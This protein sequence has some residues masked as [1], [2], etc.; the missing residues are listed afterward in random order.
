MIDITKLVLGIL[1]VALSVLA[2]YVIPYLRNIA[3]AKIGEYK[4]N[5]ILQYTKIAVQA[6]EQ[7]YAGPGR[8]AEKK[9]AV[10]RF[11]EEKGFTLDA[12]LID[13]FIE[14]AVLDLKKELAE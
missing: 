7:V 11:L 2:I 6:A 4:Y 10:L 9:A 12:D 1:E 8:G 13:T 14:S 5:Q 3:K